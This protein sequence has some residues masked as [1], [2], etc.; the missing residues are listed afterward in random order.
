MI[1]ET[2]YDD[3][4]AKGEHALSTTGNAGIS[5]IK[6]SP[7]APAEVASRLSGSLY[8]QLSDGSDDTVV[9][10]SERASIHIAAITARHGKTLDLDNTVMREIV[11]LMTIYE[12]HMALGHEQAGKE[13]REKAKDLIIASLGDFPES[14]NPVG[15]QP[16]LGAIHKPKRPYGGRYDR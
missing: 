12:L 4:I 13:Y 15:G 6:G 3:L 2:E 5:E 7:I 10:A 1:R 14:G 16:P 11:L 9:R 8:E